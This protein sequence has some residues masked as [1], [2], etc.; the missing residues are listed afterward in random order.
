MRGSSLYSSMLLCLN[1]M[2][3]SPLYSS[4]LLCLN[5]MRGSPLYSSMLLGLNLMRGSSLYS[6][7][8]LCLNL[9][10]VSPLYSSMLL[11]LY[12]MRGS[13]L[14]PSM[15]LSKARYTR[16]KFCIQVSIQ[17]SWIQ[18]FWSCI[19]YKKLESKNLNGLGWNRNASY[20][21]STWMEIDQSEERILI[22][23]NLW[24]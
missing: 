23:I 22:S 8:L 10:R 16:C 7:M 18:V 4:M 2:R 14:D 12:L 15:L 24:M 3:G 5:L 13:P 1:L 6:S 11:C 9:M 21:F 19:P 20:F 17:V